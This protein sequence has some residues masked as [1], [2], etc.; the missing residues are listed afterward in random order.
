MLPGIETYD[1]ALHHLHIS[2]VARITGLVL[3]RTGALKE[4]KCW[5]G[6]G[7]FT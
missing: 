5:V 3:E 4:G 6:S 1:L 2:A 7:S